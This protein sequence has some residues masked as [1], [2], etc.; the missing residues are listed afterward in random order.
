MPKERFFI[1]TPLR[2][3]ETVSLEGTEFHHFAH[4]MKMKK[5]DEVDLVNGKGALS[6]AIVIS[7]DRQRASLKILSASLTPLSP[8]R[9][10]L[11][12]PLMRPSKLEWV[13]EKGT[14]L[15]ADAFWLYQAEGSEKTGLSENQQERFK[16]IAIS[17]MKQCGRLDLPPIELYKNLDEILSQKAHFFF[18]DTREA[19]LLKEVHEAGPLVFITGPEKGFSQKELAL[20]SKK[21][22]GVRLHQNI[23]RA[24]TAPIAAIA[25]LNLWKKTP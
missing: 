17:A 13:L 2:E 3:N 20:L 24:E 1:D 15:G 11:A 8:P 5:G 6:K 19:P 21:A 12:I 14:E 9:F 22:K 18:G 23:L 16:T 10:I 25:I 7:V 4:V